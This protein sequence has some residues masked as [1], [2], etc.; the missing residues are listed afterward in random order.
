MSWMPVSDAGALDHSALGDAMLAILRRALVLVGV[1]KTTDDRPTARRAINEAASLL[2]SV[3]EMYDGTCLRG[4]QD[5]RVRRGIELLSRAF[6]SVDAHQRP[7]VGVT[8]R[9]S[10]STRSNATQGAQST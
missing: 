5:A 8:G 7:D 4:A 2:L 3:R 9:P 1:G 10:G 6:E